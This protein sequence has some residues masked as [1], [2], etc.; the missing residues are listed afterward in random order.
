MIVAEKDLTKNLEYV[1][2]NR[3]HLLGEYSLKYLLIF[4]EDVVSSFD[5]YETAAN[6]GVRQFGID[7]QFLV[8]HMTPAKPI[9]FV[10]EACL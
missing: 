8:Q 9:N 7:G 3:E 4:E 10:M 1:K 2:K 5:T 6:E